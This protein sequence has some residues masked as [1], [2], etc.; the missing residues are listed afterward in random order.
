MG[1]SLFRLV[2]NRATRGPWPRQFVERLGR[3][4]RLASPRSCHGLINASRSR[5]RYSSNLRDGKLHKTEAE[6]D[7]GIGIKGREQGDTR[8]GQ[9]LPRLVSSRLVLHGGMPQEKKNEH[10]RIDICTRLL[11][12]GRITP[13]FEVTT[14]VCG[15]LCRGGFCA[16]HLSRDVHLK[17]HRRI[18]TPIYA[19]NSCFRGNLEI[20]V[21]V[22]RVVYLCSLFASLNSGLVEFLYHLCSS[23]R[24]VRFGAKVTSICEEFKIILYDSIFFA[25][26]VETFFTKIIYFRIYFLLDGNLRTFERVTRSFE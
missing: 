20:Y 14:T 3:D 18:R 22:Y 24:N 11:T 5:R 19:R 8:S 7:H 25:G 16:R 13:R 12:C 4:G 26:D 9:T 21:C 15:S 2:I 17:F 23:S 10:Q 6:T 1:G